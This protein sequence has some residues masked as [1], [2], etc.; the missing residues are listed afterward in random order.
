[1][2]ASHVHRWRPDVAPEYCC[3]CGAIGLRR[4]RSTRDA[5]IVPVDMESHAY[6]ERTRSGYAALA[7]ARDEGRSLWPARETETTLAVDEHLEVG[8]T[9]K[10]PSPRNR[11]TDEHDVALRDAVAVVFGRDDEVRTSK[12]ASWSA[13]AGRL[14]PELVVTPEA[15]RSRWSAVL[16]RER[17]AA[18]IKE[19]ARHEAASAADEL[20]AR[21]VVEPDAWE[22]LRQRIDEYEADEQAEI[23]AS[24]AGIRDTLGEL[25]ALVRQ[26]DERTEQ[27]CYAALETHTAVDALL[28]EWK[29]GGS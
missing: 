19:Q 12:L 27:T 23:T 21:A 8:M 6:W 11:W 13:V 25:L 24:L 22:A 28:R 10:T 17:L 14:L 9:R 29:G 26:L 2:T 1:M 16:E 4:L 7:L 15:V 5:A 20:A 3:E 18:A